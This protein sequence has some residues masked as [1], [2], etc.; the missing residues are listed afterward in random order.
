MRSGRLSKIAWLALGGLMIAGVSLVLHFHSVGPGNSILLG[1]SLRFDYPREADRRWAAI[2]EKGRLK[3]LFRREKGNIFF[4]DNQWSGRLRLAGISFQS[5]FAL[6]DSRIDFFCRDR[7]A[8]AIDFSIYNPGDSD[9]TYEL[10]AEARSGREM[11]FR[12]RFRGDAFHSERISLKRFQPRLRRLW[13]RTT[14]KG[15]GAWISPRLI[16]RRENPKLTIVIML[17]TLRADHMS[18]YGYGRKTTPAIDELSRESLVFEN[19]YSTTSWTLP[20]HVSLFSGKDVLDHG[21]LSQDNRIAESYPLFP[22]ILQRQ[23]YATAAFTGGGFIEDNYGFHRGFQIYSNRPGDIFH[24][25]SAELV[26]DNFRTFMERNRDGDCFLFLHTYQMHAPYKAPFPYFLAFNP[27]LKNNMRGV[28][29]FLQLQT[30]AFKPLAPEQRQELV[31]LYDAAI[32]YTDQTLVKKLIDYLKARNLYEKSLI[33]ILSDHG[34]EFFDHGSWE[35]GHTLYRELIRIPLLVKFPRQRITGVEKKI[36]S[37][38]DVGALILKE[39]G[40]AT[41]GWDHRSG[42]HD[43]GGRIL[44]QA[45]PE[46]PAIHN[47]PPRVSFVDERFHFLFNL[48]D[49]EKLKT[50][51]PPP[52]FLPS[53][54]LYRVDQDPQE[55]ENLY[56]KRKTDVARFEMLLKN[57]LSRIGHL[58]TKDFKMDPDLRNKLKSLGYL[59]D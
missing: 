38:T 7:D 57:Y 21:V 49:R 19:A 11:I 15:A 32:L 41:G 50:F 35:H 46:S 31:D 54:E 30:E 42:G 58:K 4:P 39:A 2:M 5:L 33:V 8:E 24:L 18:L 14:G 48:I 37:I 53:T 16:L 17:D 52:A 44:T 36:T 26:F 10:W 59:N 55:G 56:F 34:E 20:A 3:D 12:Q 45:L 40:I 22:E 29:S 51:V 1:N 6:D 47:A 27:R 9:L 13:F 43:G 23:G 28:S 25:N